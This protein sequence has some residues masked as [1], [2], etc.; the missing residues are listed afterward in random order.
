MEVKG[1][2]WAWEDLGTTVG[3]G[4]GVEVVK[5]SFIVNLIMILNLF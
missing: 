5:F 2:S 1:I 4:L 3:A